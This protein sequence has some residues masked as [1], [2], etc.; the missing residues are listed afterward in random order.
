MTTTHYLLLS[1]GDINLGI[2]IEYPFLY[3]TIFLAFQRRFHAFHS[4]YMFE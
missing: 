4:I 3:F 2:F 1:F